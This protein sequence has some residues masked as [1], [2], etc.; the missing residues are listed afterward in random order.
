MEKLI[1]WDTNLFLF[2]NDLNCPFWDNVMWF[3]SGKYEWIP[4]YVILLGVI[5]W[6]FRLKSIL[7]ILMIPVLITAADQISV[8]LF[9]EVFER[10]RPCHNPEIQHLVHT[11]NNKCGGKFGFV[12]SHAANSFALAGFLAFVFKIRWFSALILFWASLVS[13]SRVYLGVHYPADIL[14]GAMLG[15][16]IGYLVYLLYGFL[17][18]KLQRM[19]RQKQTGTQ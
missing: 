17:D 2:L 7:I 15:L 10:L 11:V 9:K 18:N 13:Y 16:L 1:Q 8:K 3:V 12:S 6:K 5:I 19:Q 4:F 14:G